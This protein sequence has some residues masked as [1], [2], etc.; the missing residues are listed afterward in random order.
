M[1]QFVFI[2]LD[3]FNLDVFEIGV[4]SLRSAPT[5]GVAKKIR[6]TVYDVKE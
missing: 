1:F 3:P 4:I 6:T 2:E 5:D